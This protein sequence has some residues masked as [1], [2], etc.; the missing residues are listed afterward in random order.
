M[1]YDYINQWISAS[2]QD[3]LAVYQWLCHEFS[4][5]VKHQQAIRAIRDVC[6]DYYL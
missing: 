6:Q 2:I 3:A 1:T 5:I 4:D